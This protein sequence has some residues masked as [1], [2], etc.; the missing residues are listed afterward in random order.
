MSILLEFLPFLVKA[1]VFVVRLGIDMLCLMLAI[2][3]LVSS[4][5]ECPN[6]HHCIC[7]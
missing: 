2:P 1:F 7:M 5:C 6:N 3:P 4:Y